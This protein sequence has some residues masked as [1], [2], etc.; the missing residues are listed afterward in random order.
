MDDCSMNGC[1]TRLVQKCFR[2]PLTCGFDTV[3]W[4]LMRAKSSWYKTLF[5][6]QLYFLILVCMLRGLLQGAK[7]N[8]QQLLC[9]IYSEP[10]WTLHRWYYVESLIV[11]GFLN[12]IRSWSGNQARG[13]QALACVQV[14]LIH[15][16]FPCP[17]SQTPWINF[18]SFNGLLNS[19]LPTGF[20]DT[21]H[22]IGPTGGTFESH[23]IWAGL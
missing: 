22:V 1:C 18:Y 5:T 6:F 14:E 8:I 20:S 3:W 11:S 15:P 19:T 4:F 12:I 13:D 16:W 9:D 21:Q 10:T 23:L 7:F 17:D 2:A